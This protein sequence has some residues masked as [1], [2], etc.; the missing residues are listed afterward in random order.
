[1]KAI[2]PLLLAAAAALPLAAQ[3]NELAFQFGRTVGEG[4]RF[5]FSGLPD[6]VFDE[7]NGL[8]GGIVYNRKLVGGDGASLH[9][10]LPFFLME[11]RL[12][13]APGAGVGFRDT[14]SATLFA[15]PGVQVRFFEP[16]FLQPF[17]FAGVGY[18]RVARGNPE[19]DDRIV[20]ENRGTWGVSAGGGLDLVF[21]RNFGLRGEIRS[22]TAGGS[23]RIVPGLTLNDPSTRWAATGG[24]VFRF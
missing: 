11:N 3:S 9:L 15:T 19:D 13:D 7:K 14:S 2:L 17:V 24:L 18:A 20:F 10:H 22:L 23:D 4:R 16:F 12:P 6:R 1:M 8:A 21:G 5:Q